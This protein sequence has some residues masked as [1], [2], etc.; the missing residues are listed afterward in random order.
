V[1]GSVPPP[2]VSID[3]LVSFVWRSQVIVRSR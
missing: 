3:G 2:E 1:T